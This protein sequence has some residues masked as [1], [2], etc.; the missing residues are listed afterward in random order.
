MKW[1]VFTVFIAT[2][3]LASGCIGSGPLPQAKLTVVN[4][5]MTRLESGDVE[6]QVTVKNTTM[7][8]AELAQ[9]TVNFYDAGK[10]LIDSSSDSIMNLGPGETWD[11]K[12][13]C[14]RTRCSEVSSYEIETMVGTSSER[15]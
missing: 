6:V 8:T 13:A 9:V 5:E 12:L 10:G 3:T 4:H 7:A 14:Q 1:S 2:I 11:F 15:F